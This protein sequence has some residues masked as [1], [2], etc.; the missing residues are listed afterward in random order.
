M[1]W[2]PYLTECL[3]LL[4]ENKDCPTD[5]LLVYLVKV[6]LICNKVASTAW[7]DDATVG[8]GDKRLPAEFY[9]QIFKSELEEVKRAMP[10]ELKTNGI[11]LSTP[12]I[13]LR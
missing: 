4:A 2:T 10:S 13:Y 11:R 1:Q 7:T 6:Q 9:L 8:D 5:Q 12:H 3:R